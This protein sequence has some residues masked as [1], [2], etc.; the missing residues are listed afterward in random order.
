MASVIVLGGCGAVESVVVRILPETD[1]YMMKCLQPLSKYI[2][3]IVPSFE[4]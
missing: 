4:N 2:K 3:K 1:R